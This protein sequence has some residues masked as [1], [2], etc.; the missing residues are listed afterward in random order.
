MPKRLTIPVVMLTQMKK[1][2][3]QKPRVLGNGDYMKLA[4][5]GPDDYEVF[6]QTLRRILIPRVP[7]TKNHATVR[8]VSIRPDVSRY[9]LMIQ[10]IN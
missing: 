3:H 4:A 10:F 2:W 8:D 5:T 9:F 1:Q 6:N 7:G